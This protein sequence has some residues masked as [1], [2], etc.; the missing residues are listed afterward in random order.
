MKI[1]EEL[2][3]KLMSV[4]EAVRLFVKDG[5]QLTL[6]GFTVNRNPMALVRE[7]IRQ[8]KKDLH[9][10][11]HSHGQ[12]LDLLIGAGCVK[13]VELAYGGVARFA[14]TAIRFRKAFLSKQIDVEDYTNYQMSLRFM[15]GALGLPF[16]AATTGLNTDVIAREGFTREVRGHGKVARHKLKVITNPLDESGGDVVI[17]PP[18]TPDVCLLHTQT[19][20]S[21]G[22]VRIRGLKFA[23]IEQA[24]ASDHVIVT[25]EEIVPSE[26][27]RLD[28]DQNS[29]PHFLVDAVICVPF[30]A[31]PT[32]CHY[33]YDYDPVHLRLCGKMFA[34]DDLF[35]DYLEEYVFSVSNQDQYLSKFTARDFAAI[36]AN[37][38]TGYNIGLDRR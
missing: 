30:G 37:S 36:K 9:L 19:V 3:E 31:H 4:E 23:D 38:V 18:L 5:A 24:Q 12:G 6:S 17:L 27:L 25:C 10:V 16:M 20:G 34:D 29:L 2:A 13:R 7:I 11:V 26:M 28:P 14:P 22:T 8:G 32:A 1:S 21:D 33:F 15:A 35:R